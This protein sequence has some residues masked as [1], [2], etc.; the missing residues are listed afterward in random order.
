MYGR[1]VRPQGRYGHLRKMSPL[2]GFDPRTIQP[3]AG[4]YTDCAIPTL[5]SGCTVLHHPSTNYYRG[6]LFIPLRAGNTRHPSLGDSE[7][8]RGCALYWQSY[9][10]R[11]AKSYHSGWKV[12][13]KRSAVFLRS[14]WCC[15]QKKWRFHS[16]TRNGPKLRIYAD[17]AQTAC[18]TAIPK[19][20]IHFKPSG[21]S[22]P[23]PLIG[24]HWTGSTEIL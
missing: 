5:P 9:G 8:Q 21:D 15:S 1:L 12:Y 22:E 10:R 2:S 20:L 7:L 4:R 14:C 13:T 6:I 23:Q 16:E 17:I 11:S 24:S 19:V 3:V 18:P